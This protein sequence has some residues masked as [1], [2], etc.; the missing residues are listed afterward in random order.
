MSGSNTPSARGIYGTQG[1]A[2]P[3][4][5]PGARVL[6][7]TWTN[8]AGDLWLFGGNGIGANGGI[9]YLNDLWRYSAG[10]WTW[11]AGSQTNASQGT[12]GTM[13]IAATGNA[14]GGRIEDAGWIDKSGNF[15]IFGGNGYDANGSTGYLND[16]WMYQP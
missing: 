6:A 9:A 14:P 12:Y 5:T 3:N 4:N 15:W 8:A 2:A 10:Q 16:L 1:I 11:V 13:G 7:V